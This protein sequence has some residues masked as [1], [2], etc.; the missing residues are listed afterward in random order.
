LQDRKQPP[1]Q[2]PAP[3]I[4]HLPQQDSDDWKPLPAG[5]SPSTL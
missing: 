3:T 2:G 1:I 5:I 4:Q